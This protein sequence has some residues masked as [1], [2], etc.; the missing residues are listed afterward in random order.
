[1]P[2]KQFHVVQAD[3][4][5]CRSNNFMSFRLMWRVLQTPT[6]DMGLL[7]QPKQSHPLLDSNHSAWD[8]S[9]ESLERYS[10]YVH[11]LDF[12]VASWDLGVEVLPRCLR[13]LL[14]IRKRRAINRRQHE[15]ARRTAKVEAV[16]RLHNSREEAFPAVLDAV[17]PDDTSAIH[18]P[19]T[20]R[21]C[22]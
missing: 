12:A 13:K 21:Q 16:R 2:I 11:L 17:V 7:Q 10:N 9:L 19:P 22:V 4:E 18:S 3:V 1:M 14:H 8:N 20:Q 15:E 5:G 6:D